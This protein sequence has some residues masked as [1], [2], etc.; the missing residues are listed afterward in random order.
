MSTRG[1]RA[2]KR[3]VVLALLAFALPA[4]FAT[5]ALAQEDDDLYTGDG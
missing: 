5:A 2:S 1:N 4:L 3:V